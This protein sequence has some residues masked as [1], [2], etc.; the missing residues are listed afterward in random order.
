M[1]TIQSGCRIRQF[2]T[3]ALLASMGSTTAWAAELE[4]APTQE[5]HALV[6]PGYGPGVA[7]HVIEGPRIPVCRPDIPCKKPLVDASVMIVDRKTRDTR[8]GGGH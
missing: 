3:A 2:A 5:V 4:P 7:G 8:R 1:R 6:V